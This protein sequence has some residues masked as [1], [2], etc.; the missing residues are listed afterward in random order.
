MRI[1]WLRSGHRRAIVGVVALYALL[2]QAFVAAATPAG[3]I[4][5]AALCAPVQDVDQ[6]RPATP[7][8]HDPQC[9][10]ALHLGNLALPPS[11]A[12]EP[13]VW[14]RATAPAIVARPEAAIPKTG[15]PAH[16][17]RPRGPPT[18]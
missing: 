3:A 14:G 2:L 4:I 7:T 6:E 11:A 8:R 15:P 13:V 16:A 1:G 17:H 10:I 18:V 12:F 5:P 9:C